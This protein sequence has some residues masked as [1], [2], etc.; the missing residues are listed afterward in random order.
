MHTLDSWQNA[1]A[2][3]D[4]SGNKVFY[5]DEGQRNPIVFLHGYPSAGYDWKYIWDDLKPK[6]RL[7]AADF[8]GFG[9]SD[10]PKTLSYTI[11]LQTDMIV[12]LL[13]KLGVKEYDLVAHD[14]GVSVAQELIHRQKAGTANYKIKTVCLLNGGLFP[15]LHRPVLMQKLLVS[16]LG[17]LLGKLFTEQRFSKSFGQV[18]APDK[19]PNAEAMHEFWQMIQY[20]NGQAI[21]HKMLHYIAD[22]K[23][24]RDNWV[25]AIIDPPMPVRLINGS[26]DPVSGKHLA[27]GYR[28]MVKNPDV[29][30]LPTT[31]H[32]PQVESPAEVLIAIKELVDVN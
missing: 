15:E 4:Y 32:Y 18:F 1:G 12:A 21:I 16:P 20:N 6:H 28:A 29:V 14:Y 8:L 25:G 3:F 10:K 26:L 31:G 22:R 24:N 13:T 19:K 2:Y 5:V 9:F 7:I 27:N 11:H 23:A 17:P 30:E